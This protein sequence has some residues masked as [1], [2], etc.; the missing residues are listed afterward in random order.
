MTNP[1]YTFFTVLAQLWQLTGKMELVT[2]F[3][4]MNFMYTKKWTLPPEGEEG[5][6]QE[7]NGKD[8]ALKI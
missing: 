5:Y 6:I 4:Q 3:Y 2:Y 1:K 8:L 7:S